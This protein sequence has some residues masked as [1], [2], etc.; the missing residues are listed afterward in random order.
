MEKKVTLLVAAVLLAAV[1]TAQAQEGDLHGAIDLTF[2]SQYVWRGFDVYENASALQ[3]SVDLDLYQTGFGFRV[4]GHMTNGAGSIGGL[5]QWEEL[6]RWDYTL[7]YAN[8]VL[9]DRPCTTNYNVGWVYY[10]YPDNSSGD[11]DLQELHAILSWP[12]LLGIEGL[13]PSY[14]LVKL[15]PSESG[16]L[17]GSRAA[18]TGT[19]SGWAHIF[20]LDYPMTVTGLLPEV[21]EQVLNWHAELV[22]NDGVHPLGGNA[23]H[24]WSNAVIG[25]STDFDLGSGVTFTPGVYYQISMDESVNPDDDEVWATVGLKYAF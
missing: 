6:E 10:N 8:S 12:K 5:G 15:W 22:Y 17:V 23:D 25:V 9:E 1:G 7:Y 4:E 2:Q 21:P 3:P 24:D 11:Y 16:S 20:L 19:A 13:V 18:G 14:C